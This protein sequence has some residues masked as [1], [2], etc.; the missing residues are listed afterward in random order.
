M[1]FLWH[2]INNVIKLPWNI[3]AF[4][5]QWLSAC[6]T[7]IN[8]IHISI[9]ICIIIWISNGYV[10]FWERFQLS[11]ITFIWI[12]HFQK[13]IE[14][15]WGYEFQT[16]VTPSQSPAQKLHRSKTL[17]KFSLLVSCGQKCRSFDSFPD[18]KFG[19]FTWESGPARINYGTRKIEFGE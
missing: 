9:S 1:S 10:S 11:W 12:I 5:E 3:H 17:V 8:M 13:T 16:M 7:L 19:R 15:I 4:I 2:Q 6:Q 14:T 18:S